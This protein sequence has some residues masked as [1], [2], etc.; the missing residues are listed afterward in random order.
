MIIL[1]SLDSMADVQLTCFELRLVCDEAKAMYLGLVAA[2]QSMTDQP[3]ELAVVERNGFAEPAFRQPGHAGADRTVGLSL[4][5]SEAAILPRSSFKP[6]QIVVCRRAR[7]P[8]PQ[9]QTAIAAGSHTGEDAHVT[10]VGQTL[11]GAY[12]PWPI[13]AV[14]PTSGS[15]AHSHPPRRVQ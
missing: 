13:W 12:L 3:A 9:E 15:R 1:P 4:G 14:H 2:E 10:V 8:L 11:A 7:V 6:W 5:R